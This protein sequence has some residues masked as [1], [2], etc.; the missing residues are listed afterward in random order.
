MTA[1]QKLF[2]FQGRLRRRDWWLFGLAL[3]LI[4]AMLMA[5]V[6]AMMG[7]SLMPNTF[8]GASGFDLGRWRVK[9]GLAQII[10]SLVTLWPALALGFKRLHDRGRPG[11]WAAVLAAVSLANQGLVLAR[12]LTGA[13]IWG[14]LAIFTL[15]A[16]AVMG[17]WLLV[18]MGFLD[19][20]PGENRFGPSPKLP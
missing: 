13:G 2:G 8:G 11:W 12:L 10:V 19:G 3:A 15:A 18:E 14:L 20:T 4:S 17:L 16:L 6:M 9:R 1:A 5:L 7:V